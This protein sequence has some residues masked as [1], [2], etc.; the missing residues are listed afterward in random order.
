MSEHVKVGQIWQDNDKRF[1]HTPR[2]I[3]IV[4]IDYKKNTAGCKNVQTNKYTM[5][6]LDRFKP[7]SSGYKLLVNVDD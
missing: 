1:V 6:R 2:N 4:N 7:N 3:K 5:I